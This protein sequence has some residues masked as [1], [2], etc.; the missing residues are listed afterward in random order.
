MSE[1]RYE[2]RNLLKCGKHHCKI[3]IVSL[4]RMIDSVYKHF[5]QCPIFIL[6]TKFEVLA[7]KVIRVL[8]N[9]AMGGRPGDDVSQY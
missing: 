1:E 6:P 4:Q 5:H 3:V 2:I 7:E 9:A 8:Q